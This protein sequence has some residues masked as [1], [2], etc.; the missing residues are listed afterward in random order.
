MSKDIFPTIL[1]IARPAAGK[2]EII[3]YLKKTDLQTREERFHVGKI[4]E[5]DDFPFL[6]RWF[7]EDALLSEMKKDR[8]FT[9][10]EG[11]FKHIYLWDLLIKMINLEYRKFLR[12]EHKIDEK[13]MLIEFSRGK[14]HGGYRRALPHAKRQDC[15]QTIHYVCQCVLGRISPQEQAPVQSG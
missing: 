6:W 7:E 11:Y 2:S 13:T 10:P 5:I 14:E 15:Q 1:L 12:D 8:L 4:A 9:D 3:K